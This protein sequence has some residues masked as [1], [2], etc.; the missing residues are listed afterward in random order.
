MRRHLKQEHLLRRLLS[1]A[2]ALGIITVSFLVAKSFAQTIQNGDKVEERTE[3]TYY[4]TATADGIDAYGVSSENGE[5]AQVLTNTLQVTDILPEKLDFIGFETTGSGKFN[6]VSQADKT[7]VC[8]G[9][10]IDDTQEEGAAEGHW[11]EDGTEYYYHGL[12]YTPADR[13]VS[14]QVSHLQAGCELTIGIKIKTPVIPN[15][16]VHYD[17]YNTA[18]LS[19]GDILKNSNQVYFWMGRTAT[20]LYTVSFE[21]EGDVPENAPTAP[22]AISV[23]SGYIKIPQQ[24]SVAGYSFSGWTIKSGSGYTRGDEYLPYTNTVFVGHFT[25]AETPAS[26]QVIYEIEGEKP[27]NYTAPEA[28]S[29][30]PGKTV[31]ID[32]LQSDAKIGA[33][34]FAGWSSQD[35]DASAD[36]FVMPEND[37]L[38]KGTFAHNIY[39]L[40][41]AFLG[42]AP[43]NADSLL[44]ESKTYEV[45]TPIKIADEPSAEGWEFIG[46]NPAND[47]EM[48]EQDTVITGQWRIISDNFEPKISKT[49]QDKKDIYYQGEEFSQLVTIENNY[50]YPLRSV[51]LVEKNEDTIFLPSEEY[52]LIDDHTIEIYTLEANSAL[53]IH[54]KTTV[55]KDEKAHIVDTTALVSAIADG[56]HTLDTT[57]PYEASDDYNTDG[58]A[59]PTPPD[60]EVP[61][62]EDYS[63][64][65]N[66]SDKIIAV[67]SLFVTVS[68]VI[69]FVCSK[70]RRNVTRCRIMAISLALPAIVGLSYSAM[71]FYSYAKQHAQET[72]SSRFAD[73]SRSEENSW[74]LYKT[75]AWS[76]V[77]TAQ[78]NIRFN[79]IAS[80]R[81]Q[82]EDVVIAIPNDAYTSREDFAAYKQEVLDFANTFLQEGD[83][84]I[85]IVSMDAAY[86]YPRTPSVK[87]APTT[88]IAAIKSAIDQIVTKDY[89]FSNFNSVPLEAA[90]L[91]LAAEND[92]IERLPIVVAL[93]DHLYLNANYSD[94]YEAA[95]QLIPKLSYRAR[96]KVAYDVYG[97]A[98]TIYHNA[99]LETM[100]KPLNYFVI[101]FE[102]LIDTNDFE[103]T[104]IL[105]SDQHDARRRDLGGIDYGYTV[106][107]ETSDSNIRY[108]IDNF[109]IGDDF[110]ISLDLKLKNP[111]SAEHQ[112]Y[113]PNQKLN[114]NIQTRINDETVASEEYSLDR[115]P[116]ILNGFR[117]THNANAPAGC[118]V[119][120]PENRIQNATSFAQVSTDEISC[121]GYHFAGWSTAGQDLDYRGSNLFIMPEEDV[122][123]YAQWVKSDLKKSMDGTLATGSSAYLS[124][125]DF[126][127]SARKLTNYHEEQIVS[128][129]TAQSLPDNF[130]I[131][132]PN[133]IIP[134]PSGSEM[135][136]YIWYNDDEKTIYLYTDADKIFLAGYAGSLLYNFK[137]VT[138]ISA[139]ADWDT[140]KATDLSNAFQYNYA[141]SDLSPIA[142]WDVS[143][144]QRFANT[145]ADTRNIENLE[146]LSGWNFANATDLSDMF[147][148]S[149]GLTSLEGSENWKF[150]KAAA[151]DYVFA[152]TN[153]SS[154]KPTAN[155]EFPAATS[156]T[157]LF[158]DTKI[159]SLE[160]IENWDVSNITSLSHTFSG[161]YLT[162][163]SALASWEPS[164]LSSLYGTFS[165]QSNLTD[166]S[167]LASWKDYSQNFTDLTETF[168]RTGITDLKP[169]A[170]WD[171]RNVYSFSGTFANT[172]ITSIKDLANWRIKAYS[173]Y[174]YSSLYK[175]FYNT[176]LN[177]L[178]GVE[179]WLDE[180]TKVRLNSTFYKTKITN[181]DPLDSWKD[182]SSTIATMASAFQYT[183][184]L[185]DISGLANWT[186]NSQLTSMDST[187]SSCS[188]LKDISPLLNFDVSHVETLSSTF[189]NTDISS[190]HGLEN[191]QTSNVTSLS[192]TFGGT[193]ITNVDELATWNVSNV[194]SMSG[195]FVRNEKLQNVNGLA[196]WQTNSLTN[197][198]VLFAESS[199]VESF[200]PLNNWYASK[201][202]SKWNT[203]RSVPA[204]TP[205]PS[206]WY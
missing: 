205:K 139:L 135:P 161:S 34:T 86:N 95:K 185:T 75:I 112:E 192:Y 168:D 12:H 65:P 67:A 25:P 23:E 74:S 204:S 70:N 84:R 110:Q 163:I 29:Y 115:T 26:Y 155:W 190:L 109:P 83:N 61:V 125:Y 40:S 132:N 146:A 77:D 201:I 37:V 145:F 134:N 152:S 149:S 154:L 107:S 101:E 133:N 127:N 172:K 78:V 191:W 68:A 64:N 96:F 73:Y 153:I 53:E 117:V 162:D 136:I 123:L 49:I 105:Y 32:S 157:R 35:I 179:H 197:I 181:L 1:T 80:E 13:K 121:P 3:L 79:S 20:N 196:N 131:S 33:Y 15:G 106:E 156:L 183:D 164:S 199:N 173:S 170:D 120:V 113:T 31:N 180:A 160:G 102:D 5:I 184:T 56:P 118:S 76:G 126:Y 129:K 203:F 200:T 178:E 143:N 22:E 36:S 167:A 142:N 55:S 50:D 189:M 6:A 174:T 186:N 98:D 63:N 48:P 4:L 58:I 206:W 114:F 87:L 144:V 14:Y 66:T 148:S 193:D 141:L 82:A 187:F 8:T 147:V 19:D 43:E 7:T 41:Y 176:E 137:A 111:V 99:S 52:D 177:S 28:K 51:I 44:P 97:L 100:V 140:S 17:F 24:P 39:T 38:I 85:G 159:T 202:T 128:I 88:D 195:T 57:K 45:G 94:A 92:G 194:K 198:D 81:H 69:L 108:T 16:S 119:T 59:P 11:N 158:S 169:F 18:Q 122:T 171:I 2:F 71:N 47:F 151:L 150:P 175:T 182:H 10:V 165:G 27:S 188:N 104:H 21:Y 91:I 60:D 54:L 9:T 124:G 116:K 72:I 46:W 89:E 42:E 130:D 93:G 90:K 30:L 166:F 138:D 62:P 103:I